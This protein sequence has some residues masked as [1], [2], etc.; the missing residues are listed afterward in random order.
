MICP[1]RSACGMALLECAAHKLRTSLVPQLERMP[2]S[3]LHDISNIALSKEFCK[4]IS[5]NSQKQFRQRNFNRS[6]ASKSIHCQLVFRWSWSCNLWQLNW[7]NFQH[8]NNEI[9]ERNQKE[10]QRSRSRS[11]TNIDTIAGE[12]E[13]FLK[14]LLPSPSY[15]IDCLNRIKENAKQK[16][17]KRLSFS[18][19]A[20]LPSVV[21]QKTKSISDGDIQIK[22]SVW[23]AIRIVGT[24]M[25]HR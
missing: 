14:I 10:M 18:L 9:N 11:V 5:L 13:C 7:T 20:I 15:R 3:N 2:E 8:G 1:Q 17:Q 4:E 23:S 16:F 19:G 25:H 12:N 22:H 24:V 6:L 21:Q